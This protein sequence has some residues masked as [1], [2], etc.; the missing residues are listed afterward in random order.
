MNKEKKLLEDL[1]RLEKRVDS[2]AADSHAHH[3]TAVFVLIALATVCLSV[4]ILFGAELTGFVT[5]SETLS[6]ASDES[7]SASESG[8][9]RISA[10]LQSINAIMISGT[11]KGNGKAAVFLEGSGRNYLA[12]YFEGD[13]G[14]GIRFSDMCY[15]TCHINGLG[16]QNTLW[17]ELE[18]TTLTID[19]IKYIYSRIIDFELQPRAMGIDYRKDPASVIELRLTNKELTNY[20]VLLYID[21]PLSSSFGWQGSLIHMTSD[22]PE[23]TIPITV[24]LPGNLP[25]GEYVHK[26]SARYVPPDTYE[27][28]GEAP[29]AE[30]FVTVYN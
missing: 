12:Y 10:D 20:S 5:F 15:D 9:I 23:K 27:F 22:M 25:K 11:V 4:L 28:V 17:L 19:R 13:A 1:K 21:G 3:Y 18:G 14:Q 2:A 29:V 30:S 8:R 7:L 26:I 6:A 24:K 16:S